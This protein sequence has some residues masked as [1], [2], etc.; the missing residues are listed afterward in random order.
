MKRVA[1]IVLDG[2]GCGWQQDAQ[3]YG[4]V[5]ADTLGHV[6][7]QEKPAIPNLEELGL[8]KAAGIETGSEDE[9]IGCFG[10]MEEAAAGKDTTT[11]HWEIAGLTLDKPFPTYP[12][13]FPE[14]LI[15]EFE[16]AVGLETIGNKP[17]SGTQIIEEL[18]PEHLRTGKLIVYTSADSV[19]QIAAHEAIIPPAEL[20]HICRIARR[21]L[22]GEHAVGR[23][24]ARPFIGEVG[25]FT[26]TDNRRDFSVDPT[27]KTMLDVL[28]GEGY[29]VLGVGKIED[30]F[31]HR[32]LTNSNHA[33][34]NEACVDAIIEYLKKDH[35]KGLLFANLVDTDMLY[36]HRNDV[37]GFAGALEAF[38]RRLPEILKL[39]GEDGMLIITADHGCDPAFPTTDHTREKVPVLAW[40]LGLNEG[41]ELG[42]RKTFADVSATILEALG[43]RGRLDGTSFY[44][45]IALD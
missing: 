41:V 5:G 16:E 43:A 42:E 15:R 7:Q 19:F 23:V 45:E 11:G 35:W 38:D 14:E 13:G 34:G 8:L 40:G 26:R 27:G 17:A 31:N 32:G 6:Y 12:N 21:L 25:S 24:I 33:A 44:K 3:K 36:G 1:L 20:W 22:K 9:P 37:K 30:I 39:L 18:G 2:V 29:D 4:D 28:K 10:T